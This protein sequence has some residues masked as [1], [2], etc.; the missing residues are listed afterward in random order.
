MKYVEVKK[1]NPDTDRLETVVRCL[2]H[3]GNVTVEGEDAIVLATLEEGLYDRST[4]RSVTPADG[5]AYLEAVEH[6]FTNP[7]TGIAT[8]VLDDTETPLSA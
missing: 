6:A 5:V 2:E 4:K 1:Y 7:Q 3:D 8:K